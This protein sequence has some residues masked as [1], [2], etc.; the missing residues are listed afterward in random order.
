MA[1]AWFY[2]SFATKE[3]WRGA[4]IVQAPSMIAAVRRAHDLRINPGGEVLLGELPPDM[5][6][7]KEWRE[8][9]LTKLELETIPGWRLAHIER[10]G[11]KG[12]R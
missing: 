1:M 9:L 8:R 4:A 3:G 6:P 7:P 10:P 5:V 11:L 12:E 2:L